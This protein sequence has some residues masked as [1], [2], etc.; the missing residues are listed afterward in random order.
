[1]RASFAYI[2]VNSLSVTLYQLLSRAM[3]RPEHVVIAFAVTRGGVSPELEEMKIRV[4][5]SDLTL[6]AN[7]EGLS[8]ETRHF[9]IATFD[10]PVL[11]D[12]YVSLKRY[13]FITAQPS[14]LLYM[15]RIA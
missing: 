2:Q 9:N 12:I 4:Q 15:Y 1:M 8:T 11:D 7:A 10:Q 13:I 14:I 6:P 5:Q 3:P